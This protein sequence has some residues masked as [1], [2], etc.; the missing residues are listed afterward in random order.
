VISPLPANLSMNRFLKFW[1][2]RGCGAAFRA[3]LVDDADD[4]VILSRACAGEAL[5]WTRAAMTRL[6][7]ALNAAKTSIKDARTEGFDFLAYAPGPKFAPLGGRKHLGASPS[8]KSVQRIKDRTGD[9]LAPGNKA[10]WPQVRNRLN[11]LLAGWSADFSYG[12]RTPAYR[13]LD[14]H[15]SE[16]VRRF[17]AKRS[18]EPGRGT[19]L[20]SWRAIHGPYGIVS[21]VHNPAQSAAVVL[22]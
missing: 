7:L 21:L 17:L 20:F 15:V 14:H 1:R 4:F 9:L 22:P 5:A 16:R 11:R 3:R 10:P 6:G 13:A 8:K 2:M 12:T 19:R 18:R